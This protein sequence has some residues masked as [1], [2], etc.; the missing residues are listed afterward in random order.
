[1]SNIDF[2][3]SWL[4]YL[5]SFI[6]WE[7]VTEAAFKSF[8]FEFHDVASTKYEMDMVIDGNVR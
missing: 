6:E 3:T 5:N 4:C 1:M 2:G 7:P 8:T